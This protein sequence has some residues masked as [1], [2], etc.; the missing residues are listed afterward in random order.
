[1]NRGESSQVQYKVP[2]SFQVETKEPDRYY[3]WNNY[4]TIF[5]GQSFKCDAKLP[6]GFE[7]SVQ[8]SN[9]T[10]L[11]FVKYYTSGWNVGNHEMTS[12]GYVDVEV[13]GQIRI[14]VDGP[15]NEARVFSFSKSELL[16]MLGSTFMGV[17][18]AAFSGIVGFV[19][20]LWGGIK[21]LVN[22]NATGRPS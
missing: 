1:M 12:V 11:E 7:I 8:D 20:W 9:G 16:E 13:A 18:I 6:T 17:G 21:L 5:D 4:R 3:V 14:D 10:P 19:L 22:R 15:V 2:A